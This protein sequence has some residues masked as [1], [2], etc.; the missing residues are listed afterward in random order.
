M[1]DESEDES[2]DMDDE[3]EDDSG[4]MEDESDEM[5]DFDVSNLTHE[6]VME[7]M[8]QHGLKLGI[9]PSEFV[10]IEYL[11]E[12]F[13]AELASEYEID[14]EALAELSDI[15]VIGGLYSKVSEKVDLEY[16][17]EKHLSGEEVSDLEVLEHV[18][19]VGLA[20]K[21]SLSAVD[22]DGFVEEY[23]NEIAKFFKV[24]PEELPSIKPEQIKDFILNDAVNFGLDPS[25]F[26]DVDYF[27]GKFETEIVENYRVE[28]VLNISSEQVFEFGVKAGVS[29]SPLVD[30]DWSKTE[31]ADVLSQNKDSY[32]LNDDGELDNTEIYDALTG[33]IIEQGNELSPLYDFEEYLGN[34][35][36]VADLLT[37]Y[38]VESV[39][40]LSYTQI[41]EYMF[42]Q[43]LTAGYDPFS[44]E[45]LGE[46]PDLKLDTFLQAE[47]NAEALIQFSQTTT[48]EQVTRIH[49]Y[50]YQASQGLLNPEP[51]TMV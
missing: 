17:R 13:K 39:E 48:I 24:M 20:D 4:D 16:Y 14:I 37:H 35:E 1:D 9:D 51:D 8:F 5:D 45:F 18:Y 23:G 6:E 27:R 40:D 25:E 21:L 49:V 10:D 15:L 50:N 38:E 3:S 42:G 32:D 44:S 30:V 12:T 19:T 46:N 2:G 26:V 33:D 36:A 22:V 11:R 41:L 28:K 29:T 34:E 7:F 47:V 31:Y 43:G